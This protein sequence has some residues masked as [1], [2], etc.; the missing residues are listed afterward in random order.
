MHFLRAAL[1]VVLSMAWLAPACAQPATGIDGM[2]SSDTVQGL[3]EIRE[4]ARAFVER[5]NAAR[6]GTGEAW[7]AGEPNLKVFVPRC[8]VPLAVRWHTIRWSA[9]ARN[10]K[11]GELV[12]HSRRVIAVGCARAVGRADQWDVHVPVAP[13][14]G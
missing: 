11:N 7:E 3:Y 6:V 9:V 13:R 8:A 12:P 1:P 10:G 4:A 14:R 2:R 5:E